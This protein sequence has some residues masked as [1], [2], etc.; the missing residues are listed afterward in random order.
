MQAQEI[1]SNRGNYYPDT[2][3]IGSTST[4]A[5]TRQPDTDWGKP[6]PGPVISE[7]D[8]LTEEA[9]YEM[10]SGN[11]P[12]LSGVCVAL[13]RTFLKEN[14]PGNALQFA[15]VLKD[16]GGLD[17]ET[18]KR[19]VKNPRTN[20]VLV[21]NDLLKVVLIHWEPGKHSGIH[22]HAKG[23]CVFKVLRGNIIE[24]RYSPDDAQQ[25]L[26]ATTCGAGS[27]AYIDD[28]MAH[29]SVGNPFGMS[30]ISLHAYTPGVRN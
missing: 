16:L 4:Y 7:A 20:H 1:R 27:I 6:V 10:A 5:D 29:H 11:I 17:T 25:M 24:K 19:F 22:G 30:C 18:V 8:L 9:R 3:I 21:Q 28:E 14:A 2:T 12:D 23:G 15:P 26:S 13:Y